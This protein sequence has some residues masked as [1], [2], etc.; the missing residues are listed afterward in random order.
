MRINMPNVLK[1]YLE[2]KGKIICSKEHLDTTVKF[3]TSLL[4]AN[5]TSNSEVDSII[6]SKDRAMQ[7]HAFLGSYVDN[8]SNR[9]RMDILYKASDER[10]KRGYDDLKHIFKREEIHFFE[11][12]DFRS[13]LIGLCE[14]STAGKIIFYVDDMLFTHRLDYNSVRKIDSSRY[15]LSL[16]RGMDL[17]YSVVLQK[18][19]SLPGFHGKVHG[20]DCFKW[21]EPSE[22]SD[23]TFPLGVSG[24]MYGRNETIAMLKSVTFKA[25][26]TL[27]RSLQCFL[28]YFISRDGLCTEQ[29]ICA[30]V[31]ANLVQSEWTNHSQGTF[32]IEELLELWENGK[33]IDR[34]AFYGKSANVAQEAEYTFI[35]R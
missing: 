20:F 18:Q 27:E 7:L 16:S 6:F 12:L 22:F 3:A 35:D 19:I 32:S 25:P 26:N 1:K 11:E 33:M 17:T 28:P 29:A 10:H 14:K 2:M 21:S 34:Q 4:E 30:C 15:I 13:Q 5:V 8:V 23:W 31:H 24:F 9:G